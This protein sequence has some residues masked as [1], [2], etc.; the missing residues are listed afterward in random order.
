MGVNVMPGRV[1]VGVR[2]RLRVRLATTPQMAEE[3]PNKANPEVVT[4]KAIR[5]AS[6]CSGFTKAVCRLLEIA[7]SN[8]RPGRHCPVR[9]THARGKINLHNRGYIAGGFF[10]SGG[11]FIAVRQC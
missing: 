2:L 8:A 4:I 11:A 5:T 10:Y 9:L 7:L 3:R 1:C 6:R